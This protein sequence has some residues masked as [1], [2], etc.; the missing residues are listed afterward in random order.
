MSVS[1][2]DTLLSLAAISGLGGCAAFHFARHTPS[3]ASATPMSTPQT[4]R[5]IV[6]AHR[7]A[8]GERPEH[9]LMA[10]RRAIEQGADFI[11]PD[12]VLTKDGHLVCRHENEIG[13]T[14][15][16][17]TKP[18]FAARKAKK[19]IDGETYEGWFTEDFTLAELKTLRARERLPQLR[20]GNTA[21]DGLETI[22]TFDEVVLLAKA[23][24]ARL[25]RTIGVYPETKH[26]SYFEG[27][28]LSFD[29]PLLAALKAHDLDR[30]DAAI[31]IQSFEVRNLK[32]LKTLTKAPLIQLLSED[33]GPADG[34]GA[35][36]QS[37]ITD[38]GLQD[39]ASYAAGI[40]PQ[41]T[42]LIPRDAKG[43]SLAPT[44]LVARTHRVGLKLH[45][46]T[47]RAE[48]YFLAAE[49]QRGDRSQASFPALHGDLQAEYCQFLALGIDGLFSDFP[50][51]A[52]QAVASL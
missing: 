20:P 49:L 14:T 8:S 1:R 15:D 24:T 25:G 9:T 27:L 46:W 30:A 48:N 12:L 5:P 39:I 28:D 17:S 16:V 45:P 52:V 42:M 29:G 36:Y 33:G 2:R 51:S 22:P 19:V 32:R 34:A 31:F 38:A 10:Y 43:A 3:S 6:I 50:G 4:P 35:T 13:G 37:M 21:F 7:G 26:P 11:E 23:E 40:G 18:E 41:K 47:F 44:D